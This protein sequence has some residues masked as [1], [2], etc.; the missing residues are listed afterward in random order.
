MHCIKGFLLLFMTCS[1][2]LEVACSCLF[3]ALYKRLAFFESILVL[4]IQLSVSIVVL[5]MNQGA[6][7]D[8][9]EKITLGIGIT[10][11]VIWAVLGFAMVSR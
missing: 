7:V 4:D 11:V 3:A 2:L 10:A 8:E 9:A 6:D 5:V 1:T